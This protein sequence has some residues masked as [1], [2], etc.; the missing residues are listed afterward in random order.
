VALVLAV[1]LATGLRAQ[2][3][4]FTLEQNDPDPFCGETVIIFSIPQLAYARLDVW[5]PD[6]TVVVKVLIDG[7]V[8][9]GLHAVRWDGRDEGGAPVPDG[10]YPYVLT[11]AEAPGAPPLFVGSHRATVLCGTPTETETWGM[12]KTRYWAAAG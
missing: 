2:A 10:S 11:I 5:N 7:M 6:S 8:V 9:S 12:I 4:E 3:Q 1:N